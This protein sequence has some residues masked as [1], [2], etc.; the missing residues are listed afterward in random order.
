MNLKDKR[1]YDRI[2]T[3][4]L[5]TDFIAVSIVVSFLSFHHLFIAFIVMFI[6]SIIVS[7]VM[8]KYADLEKQKQ[9]R[10]GKYIRV[11]MTKAM[12]VI[13]LIGFISMIIGAWHH[14][15]WIIFL[16]LMIILF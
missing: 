12:E 4:K 16:G 11:S 1:L 14:I 15:I 9:S 10:F 2:H 7:V 5:W 3:V 6:P 13:R 8:I